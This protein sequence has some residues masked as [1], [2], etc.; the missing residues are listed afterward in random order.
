MRYAIERGNRSGQAADRVGDGVATEERLLAVV[1]HKAGG[2]R[3]VVAE[4]AA[5][6]PWSRAAVT[7][8][9]DP[10]DGR[11]VRDDRERIDPERGERPRP[12][13]LYHYVGGGDKPMEGF[14]VAGVAEVEGDALMPGVQQVVEPCRSVAGPVRATDRFDLDYARA[15]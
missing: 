3:G 4:R 10:R 2:T 13:R 7:G 14:E 9:R 8:D 6:R 11:V 5:V 15:G 12:R 1:R